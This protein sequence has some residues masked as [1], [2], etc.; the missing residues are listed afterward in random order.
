MSKAKQSVY[1][2]SSSDD[3]E[4]EEESSGQE[5]EESDY[6]SEEEEDETES[7]EEEDEEDESESESDQE[8]EVESDESSDE[9]GCDEDDSIEDE[10]DDGCD[11]KEGK[12]TDKD[13]CDKVVNLLCQRN[14]KLDVLKLEECKAYLRK[15]E[16]IISGGKATC[17]QRILE[18]WRL[19]DGKGERLYPKSSFSINCTG[20]VCQGDVVI[21]KQRVYD[22]S[23]K[24]S[25]IGIVIGKRTIA[26]R[27][28]KESYGR[29]KQQHTFTVE[30][31]WSKGAH[32]LPSLH[33]LLVKGRNL[34]RYRTFRQRWDN[35]AERSKV[36]E[37][38]HGRGAIARHIRAS[39]KA[40]ISAGSKRQRTLTVSKQYQIK[41][42]KKHS[43]SPIRKKQRKTY[44]IKA[45]VKNFSRNKQT[46]CSSSTKHSKKFKT[47]TFSNENMR[48]INQSKNDAKPP[49]FFTQ[50]PIFQN[51]YYNLNPEFHHSD[52]MAAPHAGR[53]RFLIPAH[54]YRHTAAHNIS[55]MNRGGNFRQLNLVDSFQFDQRGH[56]SQ[57]N[58][59]SSSQ[60]DLRS[61][62]HYAFDQRPAGFQ[63]HSRTPAGFQ[64]HSRTQH[65][66]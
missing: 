30:V 59:N 57:H 18:H 16:L 3:E 11:W 58:L 47:K 62:G 21:F 24:V 28:V 9:E 50:R 46:E 37:E 29:A 39:T 42:P 5:D 7:E 55:L 1:I 12:L 38:K 52:S 49:H 45:H 51:N 44:N 63:F 15:H 14:K 65:W 64:F 22:K 31:L 35:E 60:Y 19:K 43:K 33:P 2:S 23:N 56:L 40:R 6:E 34:Y 41:R 26:G 32:P 61:S 10:D 25:R 4:D 13:L 8:V 53:E 66:P 54:N 48:Q 20:D 36:L 17:I 27:I